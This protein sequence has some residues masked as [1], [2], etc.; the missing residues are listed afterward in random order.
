VCVCVCLFNTLVS[1]CVGVLVLYMSKAYR[2]F[3]VLMCY[4]MTVCKYACMLACCVVCML[5]VCMCLCMSVLSI[6]DIVSC[7]IDLH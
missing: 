2:F 7:V 4:R 5:H 1:M 3:V 6:C